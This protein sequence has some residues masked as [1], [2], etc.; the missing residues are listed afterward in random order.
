MVA[1]AFR[2]RGGRGRPG[3]LA[4]HPAGQRRAGLAVPRLQP[5]LRRATAVYGWTVGKL[6]RISALVLLVYGGLLGLTVWVFDKAPTGFIPQQDQG[7]LIVNVQ[8]PDSASLQRTQA[9]MAKVVE[10]R[11]ARRR[12]WRTRSPSRDVVPAPGQRSNFGSMFIVL[13]PFDE[14]Q[15]PGLHADAIMASCARNM[16]AGQGRRR[17]CCAI[18]RRA[19][20]RHCQR[21]QVHGR[22]PRRPGLPALQ[23]K[24]DKLVNALKKEPGLVGVF[25][26]FRSNTPQFYMDV[27]RTK[28]ALGVSINDL[29]QT[30]QI[31]LGSLY[32]N[33]F[34]AFGRYWQVNIMA[35]GT[36]RNQIEDIN[37]IKVRNTRG[38]DGP[39]QHA[40]RPARDRRPGHGHALQSL[41][42]RA[43]Q[44]RHLSHVSSGDA[45]QTIDRLAHSTLPRAMKTEWTELT[46]MQ[47]RAG[48]TAMYV[49]ALRRRRLSGLGG[50]LRKLALAAGRH[51]GRADVPALLG[52]RRGMATGRS[53][54]SCRSVSWCWWA[55]PARTPS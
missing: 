9:A 21:F 40:G 44:R 49:F 33:N 48:N 6:L 55:W 36:F 7:R 1:A 3:R 8:L 20:H 41:P 27:D 52:G 13:D 4:D 22:G 10:D 14:R 50:A 43:D 11:P 51:P 37:Q 46:L 34:N 26:P 16:P 5:P 17:S 19:R 29:N 25:T 18:P 39:A 2:A 47:I 42:G 35:D 15:K 32:V 53:T 30:L 31:Y 38:R 28:A 24:T 23:Q 45:I 54:S 12:A